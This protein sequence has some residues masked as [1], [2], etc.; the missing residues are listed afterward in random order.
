MCYNPF[1]L[2]GKTILITGASSGIGRETAIQCSK[3]GAKV[4]VTARSKDNLLETLSL[5]DGEGHKLIV[6]DLANDDDLN[7]LINELPPINGCVN[8]AGYNITELVQF[9][10]QENMERI[11]RVNTLAPILLTR[12]IV[13]SKK[14]LKGSSIVFTSSI[15]AIGVASPG[16]SLYSSTKGAL[17]AFM[18]NAAWELAPRNIRCNAVLP[19]MVETPLKEEKKLITEEQWE[20]ARQLYPLKRFGDPKDVALAIVYFLSDASSWVTGTELIIDG[21]RRLN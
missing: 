3:M 9:I 6:A 11:F 21:G 1:S 15:A 20:T 18:R 13:K 7:R 14:I 19:G 8:N 4:I 12:S 16:N 2:E 17:S 10:K 5:L